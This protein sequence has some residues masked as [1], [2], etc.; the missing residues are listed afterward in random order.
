[1]TQ[2]KQ[3]MVLINREEANITLMRKSAVIF[4]TILVLHCSSQDPINQVLEVE[5]L[6]P[7]LGIKWHKIKKV[8]EGR[9][10][11]QTRWG[12]QESWLA[13]WV[14]TWAWAREMRPGEK[15]DWGEGG[16]KWCLIFWMDE[17]SSLWWEI[18]NRGQIWKIARKA[19]ANSQEPQ[20]WTVAEKRREY[21]AQWL[22][23]G[24]ARPAESTASAAPGTCQKCKFPPSC[25]TD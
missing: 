2:L 24:G 22:S 13:D 10:V 8:T 15:K 17:E 4:Q 20:Y 5:K 16:G 25:Q 19:V 7:S 11:I 9:G 23:K 14:G 3:T 6:I 1:M 21:L 18:L 12:Q